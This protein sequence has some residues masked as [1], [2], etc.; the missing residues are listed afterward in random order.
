MSR[1]NEYHDN[2]SPTHPESEANSPLFGHR[3]DDFDGVR[4]HTRKKN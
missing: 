4:R 2:Y 1:V 3:D